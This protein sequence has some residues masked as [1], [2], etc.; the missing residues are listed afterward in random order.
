MR[1]KPRVLLLESLSKTHAGH[2][3][4]G[5]ER[6]K[7]GKGRLIRTRVSP[8]TLPEHPEAFFLRFGHTKRSLTFETPS[9][10]SLTAR[11]RAHCAVL[12]EVLRLARG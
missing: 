5:T 2:H 11:V 8:E 1:E 3:T 4:P 12:D 10:F 6:S 9:E 7:T